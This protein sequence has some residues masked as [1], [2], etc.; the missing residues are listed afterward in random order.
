M[1]TLV[2]KTVNHLGNT[3]VTH[4]STGTGHP[5]ILVHG[6]FSCARAFEAQLCGSLGNRFHLVAI[7]L[8]GHGTSS[9][10]FLP[11]K[12]YTLAGLAAAVVTVAEAFDAKTAVFVGVGLG[13]QVVL[14]ASGGLPAA[15]GFIVCGAPLMSPG[16]VPSKPCTAAYAPYASKGQLSDADIAA[17]Q[18]LCHAPTP[19][20]IPAWVPEVIRKTDSRFR[21][22]FTASLQGSND[23]DA[24]RELA[25]HRR[26]VCVIQGGCDATVQ[27]AHVCSLQVK[28]WRSAVQLIPAVGAVV[29]IL[30]PDSFSTLVR[31]F[32]LDATNN[33]YTP[34]ELESPFPVGVSPER[35]DPL[36]PRVHP[37]TMPH[38]ANRF[39]L[40]IDDTAE[41]VYRPPVRADAFN[42]PYVH[43]RVP[44]GSLP[45]PELRFHTEATA[46]EPCFIPKT[47]SKTM[48]EQNPNI[49]G[50]IV[51]GTM[52]HHGAR[53]E[54]EVPQHHP[55]SPERRADHDPDANP[56]N[57]GRIVP[58]TI[59]HPQSR[60]EVVEE[61]KPQRA[62]IR[63]DARENPHPNARGRMEAGTMPHQGSRFEAPTN[64]VFPPRPGTS[65]KV[66][67][68]PGGA[69]SFIFG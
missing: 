22:L 62:E 32:V 65:T 21:P 26:P 2:K 52:P 10:A 42:N 60:F 66:R 23:T 13:G 41:P 43:G 29:P 57:R 61:V 30:A 48:F 36:R 25:D 6:E 67:Q 12:L 9:N 34:Y 50:R 53:F 20:K 1:E 28:L 33:Y 68:P 37:G 39:E 55:A 14:A 27:L 40:P 51:P 44:P 3:I 46:P 18:S 59:P 45:H 4:H 5:V 38:L 47:N 63:P 24:M 58:G 15:A 19:D 49:R 56:N 54:L 8:P 35:R 17:I 11:E 64:D 7:E 16:D 31:D 69:T